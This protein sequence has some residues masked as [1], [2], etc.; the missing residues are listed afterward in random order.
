[1][2]D[3]H[4]LSPYIYIYIYIYITNCFAQAGCYSRS[5][6]KR[7]F[8]VWT[9]RFCFFVFLQLVDITVEQ[10]CLP[11]DLPI[12]EWRKDGFIIFPLVLVLWNTKGHF[13][14]L[15]LSLVFTSHYGNHERVL[16][17]IYI[18]VCVCVYVRVCVC[19]CVLYSGILNEG[20]NITLV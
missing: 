3:V 13:Q 11:Y 14:D 9:P 20:M 8:K 1:M 17:Y 2:A 7:S 6:L 5:N 19:V 12:A 4:T 18:C 10:L 15:N 16:L